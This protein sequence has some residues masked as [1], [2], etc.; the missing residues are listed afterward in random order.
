MIERSGGRRGIIRQLAE[1]AAAAGQYL[2]MSDTDGIVVR[3][4]CDERDRSEFESYGIALG[5]C[6][7]ERVAGTNGV[8]MALSQKKAITVRGNEHFFTKYH[9]FVCTAVPLLDAHNKV[10]GALNLSSIDREN[11]PEYVLAQCLLSAAA[12]KIQRVLFEQRFQEAQLIAISALKQNVLSSNTELVAIDDAGNIVGATAEAHQLLNMEDPSELLGEPFEAL[13]GASEKTLSRVHEPGLNAG[14]TLSVSAHRPSLV[15]YPDK[16][17]PTKPAKHKT[18]RVRRRL[19]PTIEQLAV[20]SE[21]FAV[22]IERAQSYFERALPFVVEGESGTGKSALIEA[23]HGAVRQSQMVTID[24]ASLDRNAEDRSYIRMIL[25]RARA[26]DVLDDLDRD[27]ATLVLDNVDE[28][29]TYAQAGLRTLLAAL[30]T[31]ESAFD[32]E[33]PTS[34]LRVV[35]TSRKPLKDAVEAGRFRDDLYFLLSNGRFE[36]PPLRQRERPEALARALAVDL[37][38]SDVEITEEA[39]DKIRHHTWPGNVRELRNTLRQSLI[40]GDGRRIS[41]I[42]LQA[43]SAFGVSDGRALP[44]SFGQQYRT[45]QA[46]DEKTMIVDALLGANWN[47]SRAARKLGMGRA[48]IHRKMK[49]HGITR[50]AKPGQSKF[51]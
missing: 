43:S 50:P 42:N 41:L 15:V 37:A 13:F 23:L 26:I 28:L 2:V 18:K 29:P 38:A 12:V 33:V 19:S 22:V 8:A 49:L 44:S 5:S 3:L 4:E 20:G 34:A 31:A 30:E 7:D 16:G 35:A 14:T 9:P 32:Q 11:S 27:T 45:I 21:S 25:G 1:I 24:C 51:D 40:E 47:V 36:I 48:T 17:V 39:I 6:L 46:Y 10:F